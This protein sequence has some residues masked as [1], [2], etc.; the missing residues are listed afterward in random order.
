VPE[1]DATSLYGSLNLVILR[2]LNDGELHGLGI[3]R[4]LEAE[5]GGAVTVEVGALY[6]ALHRLEAEGFIAGSWGVSEARR[7]AKFYALTAAGRRRLEQE[8]RAWVEHVRTLARLLGVSGGST[9]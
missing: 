4:R 2:V 6:P 5:S 7:R 1:I 9:A 8:T 3:Q